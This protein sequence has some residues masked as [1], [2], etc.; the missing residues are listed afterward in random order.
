MRKKK[1]RTNKEK[2][3]DEKDT[4]HYG[5]AEEEK[6]NGKII[7]KTTSEKRKR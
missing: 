3:I 2:V 4:K 5:T 7:V 6:E 1:G